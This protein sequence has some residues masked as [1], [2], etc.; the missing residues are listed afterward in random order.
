[1]SGKWLEKD[2]ARAHDLG[3][4]TFPKPFPVDEFYQWLDKI[5]K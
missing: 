1:M 5:A 4:K 2:I 3:C